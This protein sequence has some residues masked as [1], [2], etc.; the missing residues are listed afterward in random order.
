ME[1]LEHIGL[2]FEVKEV[3]LD[4]STFEGLSAGIGNL[5]DGND[6]I[7]PGAFKRTIRERVNAGKV[8][9]LDQHIA[10]NPFRVTTVGLWGKVIEAE[11]VELSDVERRDLAKRAGRS[12]DD[13]PSHALR[14][15]TKVSKVQPAQDVLTKIAEG[16]M[17]ALSIGWI[18]IADKLE[19]V[20]FKVDKKKGGRK[21]GDDDEDEDPRFLWLIGRAERQIQELKWWEHSAVIWGQNPFALTLPGTVKELRA[22]AHEAA[23]RGDLGDA[24]LREVREVV[25]ALQALGGACPTME[26]ARRMLPRLER[27]ATLLEGMADHQALVRLEQL[28]EAIDEPAGSVTFGIDVE[29]GGDGTSTVEISA[30]A[31]LAEL[32]ILVE[33][34]GMV[35]DPA[36]GDI[37]GAEDKG[38]LPFQ[39]RAA[40]NRPWSAAREVAAASGRTQLRAM[41]AWFKTGGDP[42]SKQDYKLPHHHASGLASNRTAVSAAIAAL[43]G[44]RGGVQ[45]PGAERRAVYNH[46]RREL[47]AVHGIPSDRVPPLRGAEYDPGL[48]EN[49]SWD[50]LRTMEAIGREP[51][52]LD[53]RGD[54]DEALAAAVHPDVESLDTGAAGATTE[55]EAA[56]LATEVAGIVTEA[57]ELIAA[58]ATTAP[59]PAEATPAKGRPGT[60]T[61]QEMEAEL[62]GLELMDIEFDL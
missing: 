36:S 61:R 55:A 11:E 10:K 24:D 50:L 21:Q 30:R 57:R 62:A 27:M 2:P 40:S 41:H 28:V 18:P 14:S 48:A 46:L 43:N 39:K 25:E 38:A 22:F 53:L 12:P 16:I 45:I 59:Q 8:K 9:F 31:A 20:P 49:D 19:F 58:A 37:S 13:A 33:G 7:M 26:A 47:T 56:Q 5:D 15:L 3:D 23:E 44:A 52:A 60:L 54:F 4:R 42:E 32:V 34:Q 6:R 17:D 1:R 29:V 51:A 35:G